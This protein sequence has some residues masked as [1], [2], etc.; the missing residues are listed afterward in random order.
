MQ[1]LFTLPLPTP[2]PS[3]A[4]PWNTRLSRQDAV[5]RYSQGSVIFVTKDAMSILSDL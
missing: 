1:R 3:A 4:P 5:N 2:T